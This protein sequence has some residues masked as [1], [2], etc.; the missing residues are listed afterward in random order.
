MAS[1]LIPRVHDDEPLAESD[2]VP[3][4]ASGDAYSAPTRVGVGPAEV[5]LD[6]RF[7]DHE[8]VARALATPRMPSDLDR[9]DDAPTNSTA[10]ASRLI[11]PR[12]NRMRKR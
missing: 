2:T 9:V 7:R 4:P 12:V 5:L 6:A 11:F 10:P 1:R 8:T 3:P